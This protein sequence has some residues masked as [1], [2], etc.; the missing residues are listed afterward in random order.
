A[1]FSG[2]DDVYRFA[3]FTVLAKE[4]L[5]KKDG[6]VLQVRPQ[7]FDL[8]LI[9]LRNAGHTVT[10]AELMRDIWHGIFVT[11]GNLTQ[12]VRELREILGDQATNPRYIITQ[13]KLGYRFIAPL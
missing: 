10:K 12:L 13:A 4:R 11:E 3:S 6:S 5:L 9:L 8:L 7:V 1:R 2:N